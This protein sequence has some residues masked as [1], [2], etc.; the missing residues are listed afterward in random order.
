MPDVRRTLHKHAS[1]RHVKREILDLPIVG[2]D[3]VD[4]VFAWFY[5][6][7]DAILTGMTRQRA[8]RS[9][10]FN[11]VIPVGAASVSYGRGEC[12]ACGPALAHGTGNLVG[13]APDLGTGQA[14]WGA[15]ACTWQVV[16][17]ED[18]PVSRFRSRAWSNLVRQDRP[19]GCPLP[20]RPHA[21]L[22]R[23]TAQQLVTY[24]GWARGPGS[25]VY[26][27]NRLQFLRPDEP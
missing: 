19:Q 4:G 8:L 16:R 17:A 18:S 23:A 20:H 7:D 5:R 24:R 22:S 3:A 25:R 10:A 27:R 14:G 2:H 12:R 26:Q 15:R 13:Q 21:E 9:C 6:S 1:A 11:M